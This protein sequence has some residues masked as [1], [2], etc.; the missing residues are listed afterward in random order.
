MGAGITGNPAKKPP[1]ADVVVLQRGRIEQ[2][3]GGLLE[4]GLEIDGPLERAARTEDAHRV[5]RDLD[6]RCGQTAEPC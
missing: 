6:R 5:P 4:E 2:V 1:P 3:A